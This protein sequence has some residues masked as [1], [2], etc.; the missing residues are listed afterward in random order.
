MGRLGR[1]V[2]LLALLAAA[3]NHA[4]RPPSSS[5]AGA[6]RPSTTG[7]GRPPTNATA[8]AAASGP[9]GSGP[10][11]RTGGAPAV[12]RF[13]HIVVLVEENHGLGSIVGSPQAPYLNSLVAAGALAT[14]YHATTHPSLPNYLELTAGT[15]AGID[16]DCNPPGGSCTADVPSV[17]DQL[18]AAGL[19]WKAY[20]DGMPAPCTHANAGR[21]AVKHNPFLYYPHVRDDPTRCDAHDVPLDQ[22]TADLAAPAGLP[23]YALVVP[24]LCHDMHDCSVATGDAWLQQ[25]VPGLLAS[26]AFT[27]GRSLLVVTFDESEGGGGDAAGTDTGGTVPTIFVGS[28]VKAGFETAVRY[29]HDSLLHTIEASWGLPPL[30]ASVAAAPPITDVFG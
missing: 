12:P 28:Q 15:T 3:C 2:I 13:D 18:E 10:A 25:F 17:A 29:S 9:P 1:L 5:A 20:L 30:T 8:P 27:G 7:P 19:G 11:D 26:A 6:P 23:A 14:N 21:Y 24:D 16:N 22:L 4:G